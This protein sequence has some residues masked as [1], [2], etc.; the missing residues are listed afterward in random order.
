[1]FTDDGLSGVMGERVVLVV[2]GWGDGVIGD[3]FVGEVT[4]SD[5]MLSERDRVRSRAVS[6]RG[7]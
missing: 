7:D 6:P 3:R 5:E 4:E 2:D 1:M